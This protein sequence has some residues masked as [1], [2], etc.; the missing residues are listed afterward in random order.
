MNRDAWIQKFCLREVSDG[1]FVYL[2][3]SWYSNLKSL[4]YQGV[5]TPTLSFLDMCTMSL[6]ISNKMYGE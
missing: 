4:N 6:Y 2:E 1:Q 5:W 3:N